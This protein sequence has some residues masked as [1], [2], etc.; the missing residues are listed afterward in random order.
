[1]T[2]T[3]ELNL[4]PGPTG[5]ANKKFIFD[6]ASDF[7]KPMCQMALD[8]GDVAS[9]Y[10]RGR[11][12]VI[13]SGHEAAKHVLITNQDNYGKGPEY[14]L[15]RIILGEGLLTSQGQLWK[16]QRRLVQP[17]FAKRHLNVFTEQMT[18]ATADALDGEMFGNVVDGDIVDVSEAMMALT[19]DVV[20]RALFGADLSGDTARRVGPAMNDVLSLGTRMVRRLPT[21]VMSLLPGMN[22][23]RSIALNPEGRRFQR[24]LAE[25]RLVI[26][27]VLTERDSQVD[28]GDD[29]V[30]LMLRAT[31]DETGERMSRQ[32]IGDEL[33]TFMLAGHETTSNALSW[34]WRWLSMNPGARDR[35]LEE[36]DTNI[37]DRVPT[38]DDMELLPWTR[39]AIEEAM[40]ITPPV[41]TV[42]RKALADDVIGGYDVPA[43]SGVMVLITMIHR[44]PAIWPNP[45]GYDPSRFLPENVKSRPRHAYLPFGAG[46]RM[47]V[48]ST[49]AI[50]EATLLAAMISRKLTFDVPRGAKIEP[51]AAITMRP[52]N[53]L[54]MTVHRRT[55]A[56]TGSADVHL[57]PLATPVQPAE[58]GCP[59]PH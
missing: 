20:G 25:L 39:A 51:E 1:M 37:G 3:A 46:R 19:L 35:L 16:K 56:G 43:G 55:V 8:Y 48:G 54:P 31:D 27:E 12:L 33:M 30:G 29:L 14:E 53:G 5:L 6:A 41:W 38:M 9:T 42:G 23:E 52:K 28:A 2:Q 59:V 49:F 11:N 36:V 32:Q 57:E 26:D 44:D 4:P 7:M 47:C 50:V 21:Y 17:M 10:S 22:L 34:T 45:E 40:R 24:A 15:L 13:V 18:G 58:A